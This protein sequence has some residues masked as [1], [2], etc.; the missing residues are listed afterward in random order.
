MPK[1]PRNGTAP[2]SESRTA[3]PTAVTP[4]Q[5]AERAYELYIARG[6]AHGSDLRD[7]LQAEHELYD[8]RISYA[9]TRN[10]RGRAKASA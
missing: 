2:G 6:A 1:K 9:T 10:G 7:W 3:V 5:I 4:A 8:L